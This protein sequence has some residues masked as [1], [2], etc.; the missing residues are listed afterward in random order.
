MLQTLAIIIAFA[1]TTFAQGSW[2]LYTN[3]NYTGSITEAPTDGSTFYVAWCFSS[4]CASAPTSV[5]AT[6]NPSSTSGTCTFGTPVISGPYAPS[7][8]YCVIIPT[9]VSHAQGKPTVSSVDFTLSAMEGANLCATISETFNTVTALPVEFI[10]VEANFNGSKAMIHWSTATEVNN[11]YFVV[12]RSFDG[13]NWEE[14][15][16]ENG[17]G[18]SNEIL[19]YTAVDY[20]NDMSKDAFYRVRQFDFDGTNDISRTVLLKKEDAVKPVIYPNPATGNVIKIGSEGLSDVDRDISITTIHGKE[21]SFVYDDVNNTIAIDNFRK[22]IYL[23]TV[24]GVTT[25]LIRE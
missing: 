5:T 4:T 20:S 13:D 12:E 18:N 1:T 10:N 21:I 25:K 15:A 23:I 11:D 17:A 24:D 16:R 7:G 2:G 22:G 6:A 14:V 8:N 3:S 9:T 19:S